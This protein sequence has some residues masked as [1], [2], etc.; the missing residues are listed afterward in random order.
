MPGSIE[1]RAMLQSIA[2]A[3]TMAA[4]GS[5]RPLLAAPDEPMVRTRSGSI[6]GRIAGDVRI[7][8]G[9]PYGAAR[10]FQA[11]VATSP[12]KG[13]L[14]ATRPPNVAPQPPGLFERAAAQSEDCLQL[15]IWTPIA[16]GPHPVMI[17]LHGGANE[18]GWCGDADFAGD[19]FARSGIVF[20]G[21]NYRVGALGFLDLGEQLGSRYRGSGNNGLRDQLLAMRWVHANI[22]AFGGD[23]GRITLAGNSAG[24]KNVAAHMA[25]PESAG[26]FAQAASFS[27][28]GQTVHDMEIAQAFARLVTEKLGGREGLLTSPFAAIVE[29]Q[30]EAKAAWPAGFPF[31]PVVDG[32]FLP[33][34]PLDLI[35][36]GSARAIPLLIGTNRDES[37]LFVPPERA[38]GPLQARDIANEPL[39][40]MER[41]DQLYAQAFPTLTVAERHWRLLTDEEYAMPSLKLAEA[42]AATGADVYR[43]LL[44]H[45]APGGPFKGSVPH[46][47]E[48]P[49]LFDRAGDSMAACFF[50]LSVHDQ[51]IA[52]MLHRAVAAFVADGAPS[53]AAL[54]DWSRFSER[55]RMTMMIEVTP[56]VGA[57]PD[58]AARLI[59]K[60]QG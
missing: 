54:P 15:N 33:G 53:A 23:P 16:R 4:A 55:D 1:R 36:D 32:T 30:V 45:P 11:P 8:T 20:V 26:L 13:V 10:R 35:A 5:A 12:W 14:N 38:A 44:N 2:A 59:W 21:L 47:M 19:S 58:R 17:F 27:G 31:R 43:Y 3:A 57:D 52:D 50:G 25:R 7:F 37:R 28:G 48:L 42:Q 6:R 29:A 56:L 9:I 39:A 18:G 51:P 24:A 40:R 34:K 46:A 60:E 41:L 22:A 49:L